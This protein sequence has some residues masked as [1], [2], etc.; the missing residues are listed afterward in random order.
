[1][2]RG[3]GWVDIAQDRDRWLALVNTAV[4]DRFHTMCGFLDWLRNFQ[5]L[6]KDAAPWI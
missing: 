3:I 6:R 5:H 1:L 4:N 2:N